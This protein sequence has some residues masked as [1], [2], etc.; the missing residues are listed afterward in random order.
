MSGTEAASVAT[1]AIRSGDVDFSAIN[2]TFLTGRFSE[3]G[4]FV[5][6]L[7]SVHVSVPFCGGL[8]AALSGMSLMPC[9]LW[10]TMPFTVNLVMQRVYE[11]GVVGRAFNV[12][13]KPQ[14]V[15]DRY[16][17]CGAFGVIVA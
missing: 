10:S 15:V 12:S 2:W 17:S 4:L 9:A 1:D 5:K 3:I 13:A 7:E 6:F 16:F 14:Y 11:Y 8:L